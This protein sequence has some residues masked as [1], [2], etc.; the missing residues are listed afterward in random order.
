M[1][2]PLILGAWWFLWL[3]SSVLGQISFRL[4][5]H[6][7]EMEECLTGSQVT[8]CADVMNVA[9]AAIAIVLV[10]AVSTTQAK[11]RI[12]EVFE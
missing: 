2:A 8:L 11:S 6:A 3:A 7:G 9:L 5:M 4:S 1:R 12:E 10:R